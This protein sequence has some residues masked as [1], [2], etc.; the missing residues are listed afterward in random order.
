MT[1]PGVLWVS[2]A[3]VCF[4]ESLAAS[5]GPHAKALDSNRTSTSVDSSLDSIFCAAADRPPPGLVFEPSD[6]CYGKRKMGLV[7]FHRAG[8]G[9]YRHTRGFEERRH[10]VHILR[11]FQYGPGSNRTSNLCRLCIRNRGQW[12]QVR[13]HPMP[14][15]AFLFEKPG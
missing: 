5:H 6:A 9:S 14:G 13:S 11:A 7:F 4:A 15:L 3:C 1:K 2:R 10:Q 12:V 8:L